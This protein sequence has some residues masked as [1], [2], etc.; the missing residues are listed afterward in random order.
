MT[1]LAGSAACRSG[2]A[3]SLVDWQDR[4]EDRA[5]RRGSNESQ[6]SAVRPCNPSRD[7]QAEA[8]AAGAVAIGGAT[9]LGIDTEE[10]IEDFLLR[11]E[12]DTAP[13]VA[14]VDHVIRA[15]TMGVEAHAPA[16]FR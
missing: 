6:V 10:A 4:L 7:R 15:G 1:A 5:G 11:L 13:A 16:G 3:V 2:N 9:A 14:H 8:G 12:R